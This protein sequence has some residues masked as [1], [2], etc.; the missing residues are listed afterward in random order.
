[1]GASEGDVQKRERDICLAPKQF[2]TDVNLGKWSFAVQPE[3]LS[4][5]FENG[6]N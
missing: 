6:I 3:H 1:M 4:K 5:V 2:G